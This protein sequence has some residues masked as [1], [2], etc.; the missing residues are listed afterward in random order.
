MLNPSSFFFSCFI[1]PFERFNTAW[2]TGCALVDEAGGPAEAHG[3]VVPWS[4][5][6]LGMHGADRVQYNDDESRLI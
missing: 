2:S 6:G 3:A 5:E 4:A 1:F